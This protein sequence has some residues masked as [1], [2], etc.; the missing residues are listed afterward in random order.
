M[1]SPRISLVPLIVA[2]L[3]GVSPLAFGQLFQE[4][5]NTDR[6]ASWTVNDPLLTD[7]LVDFFYDYSLIGVPAAPNGTGTRGLKMTA[8][9][10]NAVFG[11]VSVSPTGQSFTGKY[12][13]SFDMWLNYAGPLG[14]GGSG[15]TQ[16]SFCGIGT[17]G[18][19]ATWAG[20]NPKE[21]ISFAVTHDG[22]SAS[23]YRAYSPSHPTSYP[24]GDPVYASSSLNDSDPYYAGFASVS[25]PPQQVTNFP[26]QTGSTDPGEV[27]FQWR[28]VV[29]EVDG[30]SAAWSIDGL[31][32]A[33]VPF[34]GLTLGGGNILFGH[35]DTN[36]GASSD[37]NDTLLNVT[38][39]DN[40][41]V[42]GIFD[43][44]VLTLNGARVRK[45]AK[46]RVRLRGTVTG[47][48]TRLHATIRNPAFRGTVRRNY[49]LR[50]E[51]WTAVARVK[52]GT[53]RFTLV[54]RGPGGTSAPRTVAVRFRKR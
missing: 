21:S 1:N 10:A 28:R 8:N 42:E 49:R 32:I 39:I 45:T 48:A 24:S 17:A 44:P 7:T 37:A 19:V 52:P 31:L 13:V 22:G 5:F 29:I 51:R 6:T 54:A 38:L 36:A 27:S 50:S 46:P 34:D 16:L 2:A 9:N 47:S 3:A 23:D 33:T 41:V 4:D 43:H 40:V 53:N 15:S 35:S 25:A 30:S 20:S 18:N 12:R 11:G 26:G 14:P